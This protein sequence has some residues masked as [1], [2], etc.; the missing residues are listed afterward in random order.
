MK[1]VTIDDMNQVMLDNARYQ[2]RVEG[3]ED[4]KA[5]FQKVSGGVC[6]CV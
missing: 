3:L 5:E 6:V 1:E 2:E 4:E